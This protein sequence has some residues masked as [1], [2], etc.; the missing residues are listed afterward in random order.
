[1][2]CKLSVPGLT[3]VLAVLAGVRDWAGRFYDGVMHGAAL[4][5]AGVSFSEVLRDNRAQ[6]GYGIISIIIGFIIVFYVV[7]Y[8][9]KP[10]EDAGIA[11]R[12]QLNQST[13]ANVQGLK[14]LPEVAVLLF[15][16]I[17]VLG[18]VLAAVRGGGR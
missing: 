1:M 6:A 9:Y 14:N 17:T 11:L 15:I 12:D 13:I 8:T 2:K 7:A 16:L 10:L 5:A 4:R 18:L 3:L